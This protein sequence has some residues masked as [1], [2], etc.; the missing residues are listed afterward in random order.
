MALTPYSVGGRQ[1]KPHDQSYSRSP[2]DS[3]REAGEAP[4]YA[5]KAERIDVLREHSVWV[6]YLVAMAITAAA[7]GLRRSLDVLGEGVAPFVLFYP[8]VLACTLFGGVGPGVFSF[9]AF[10]LAASVLWLEPSGPLALSGY[11]LINLLLFT[12]TCGVII[13]VAYLLRSAHFRLRRSEAQLRLSQEV[14][15]IGVWEQNLKTGSLWWSPMFYEVTGVSPDEKPDIEAF[16]QRID[17]VDRD[18]AIA[19]FEA[20]RQGH[21]VLDIQ[22]RF[23]RDD[24]ATVWLAGR[25]ELLRDADGNPSRLLGINFDVTSV[26]AIERERDQAHTLLRTLFDSLPGAAYVKDTE[27]RILL[28]NPGMAAA[29]GQIPENFLG[30]TDQDFMRDQDRARAIMEH[31]QAV[32]REGISTEFEEEIVLPD[33][34]LTHWL[35]VKTPFRNEEGRIEGIVGISLDVT[36]RRKAEKRLRFLADEVDHRAKNLLAVVQSIMRLTKADDIAAFKAAL[37]GRIKALARAHNLLAAN[38]WEG[39]DLATLVNEELAQFVRIRAVQICVSGASLKLEPN[40]SQPLAMVLHELAINAASYGA[41]S[42]E[43]G[44]L[45]VAWQLIERDAQ[46]LLELVWTEAQGPLVATRAEPGFGSTAIRGA[47]EHQLSGEVDFDWAP[48]GIVCRIV[49]PVSQDLV[50]QQPSAV[51]PDARVTG[52]PRGT[53]TGAHDADLTGKRVL[54]LDDEALIAITLKEAVE[55]LGCNVVGPVG[56]AKAALSLVRQG[57]PDIAILDVN[58]AGTSSAPVAA[59]L[60]ALG[61]PL[62]YCTGYT[63]P[64][65]QIEVGPQTEVLSKPIDPYELAAALK[66]AVG[67]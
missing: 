21:G 37:G 8:A 31:D 1:D 27:G 2:S 44:E 28:G 61:V 4:S 57:A 30:K 34:Q 55:E 39:V 63:V 48:T 62:V 5:G 6:S 19:A 14:G 45:T 47:I 7:I 29:V 36:E 18:R 59:A 13:L 23:N 15:R 10:A 3:S 33:G 32:F 17:P 22:F 41:L 20:A 24:G 49:F 25:A 40:V 65:E 46:S 38:G 58:L 60:R 16:L 64:A 67:R 50:R 66:R 52:S 54:I 42:V 26:R 9:A 56:N 53:A 11:G 43:G 35:S 12:C 51:P